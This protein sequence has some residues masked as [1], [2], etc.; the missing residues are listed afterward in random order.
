MTKLKPSNLLEKKFNIHVDQKESFRKYINELCKWNSQTNLVGISTL[1]DPYNSHILDCLQIT[2][3]I[4]NKQKSIID[5]GTGAGLPGV[6]LAIVNYSNVFL[7]DSNI[8][9]IKFLKHI[10][11][12][13][14]LSFKIFYS[15]IEDFKYLKFDYIVS[16]ALSGLDKLLFYSIKLSHN[17]TKMIFLKGEKILSEIETAEKL[18]KFDYT[19][20]DSISDTRC[21]IILIENLRKND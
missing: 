15:R 8:K 16:R 3:F 20:R 9:K 19:L 13:L 10:A 11:K 18:W 1:I 4:K 12:E 5:L 6:V 17:E 2:K 14:N 21:K 7:I